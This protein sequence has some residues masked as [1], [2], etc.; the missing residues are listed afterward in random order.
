MSPACSRCRE[1]NLDFR[2]VDKPHYNLIEHPNEDYCQHRS[3]SHSAKHK[4]S[5]FDPLC[6]SSSVQKLIGVM[7]IG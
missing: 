1:A 5:D 2:P 3:G 4:T 6:G 7:D